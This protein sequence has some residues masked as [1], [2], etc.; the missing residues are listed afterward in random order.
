M[1]ILLC[2]LITIAVFTIMEG[3]TWLTHKY[4]MHGFFWYLH[5]DHHQPKYANFFERNDL[6]FL[7]FATP[8]ITFY[9]LGAT[10]GINYL[11]FVGFVIKLF[12]NYL[13]ILSQHLHVGFYIFF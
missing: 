2:I 1:N 13:R 11:L 10:D 4:V 3:V 12:M 5:E 6:F 7:I 9:Y 8:S